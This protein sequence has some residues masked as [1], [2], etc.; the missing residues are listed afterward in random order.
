MLVKSAHWPMETTNS[1]DKLLPAIGW[2]NA[3]DQASSPRWL[4]EGTA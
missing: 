1:N 3:P 2:R 4:I